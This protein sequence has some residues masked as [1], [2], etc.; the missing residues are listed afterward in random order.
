MRDICHCK[1]RRQLRLDGFFAL[2]HR[3]LGLADHLDVAHRVRES[4]HAKVKVIQR[5]RL[6]ELGR[7]RLFRDR[8]YRCA[9]V[10]H[11]VAPDLIGAVGKPIGVLVI[12]GHQQ[13][14]GRISRAG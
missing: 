5:E 3:S 10:E 12:S 4:L 11:I 8:Q 1:H 13:Q 14:F 9:V 2:E 7:I 6:L